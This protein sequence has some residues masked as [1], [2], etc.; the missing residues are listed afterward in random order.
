MS[1][2]VTR[3]R[4]ATSPRL[5]SRRPPVPRAV[6][7][8]SL[9]ETA[10]PSLSAPAIGVRLARKVGTAFPTAVTRSASTAANDTT[11]ALM[12]TSCMR[13]MPAGAIDTAASTHHAVSTTA[14][15]IV[16][17]ALNR[18]SA[19][20]CRL[21]RLPRAPSARRIANLPRARDTTRDRET[22]DVG[23]DQQQ[24]AEHRP[25]DEKELQTARAGDF[26]RERR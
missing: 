22:G 26:V 18:L 5:Q 10:A 13:G 17:I 2:P 24:Q 3:L 16:T 14:M 9:P 19:I 21:T 11:R 25:K 7:Q 8:T 4:R 23:A 15:P 1:G 20:N 6:G 12:A